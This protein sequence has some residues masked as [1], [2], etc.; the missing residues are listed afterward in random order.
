M[1]SEECIWYNNI[2]QTKNK[3]LLLTKL[4]YH[5]FSQRE[6]HTWNTYAGYCR[7]LISVNIK[8]KPHFYISKG[9]NSSPDPYQALGVIRD[10]DVDSIEFLGKEESL[11]LY[12]VFDVL[13]INS[14]SEYLWRKLH[15]SQNKEIPN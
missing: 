11:R 6:E 12:N 15:Y 5:F 1:Q 9:L 13:I 3:S 14:Q 7:I 8:G 2:S 10:E 4:K